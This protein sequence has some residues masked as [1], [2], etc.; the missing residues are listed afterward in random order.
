MFTHNQPVVQYLEFVPTM[1]AY[2]DAPIR[3]EIHLIANGAYS[4]F[5]TNLD[6][7]NNRSVLVWARPALSGE[8]DTP[9]HQAL[10]S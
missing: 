6:I 7:L 5:L 2:R 9:I 3:I 4:I 10:G 8:V 1:I